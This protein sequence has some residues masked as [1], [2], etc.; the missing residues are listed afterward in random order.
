MQELPPKKQQ[1]QPT[2]TKPYNISPPPPPL[3]PEKDEKKGE[4]KQN[5]Y[6]LQPSFRD[7][8]CLLQE[9]SRSLSCDGFISL[10]P[11]QRNPRQR[12]LHCPVLRR[13][14]LQGAIQRPPLNLPGIISQAVHTR[15]HRHRHKS[16]HAHTHAQ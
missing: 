1:Q 5:V 8:R 14:T 2:T 10:F 7:T 4:K 16:T 12:R 3:P 11:C 13:F 6:Y 15:T 9:R